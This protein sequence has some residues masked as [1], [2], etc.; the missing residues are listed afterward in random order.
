MRYP[1]SMFTGGGGRISFSLC[2]M[3]MF[4]KTAAFS[5]VLVTACAGTGGHKP[6]DYAD[7]IVYEPEKVDVL[8]THREWAGL[9][10]HHGYPGYEQRHYRVGLRGPGPKFVNPKF[11][12]NPP[13]IECV[14]SVNL[15]REHNRVTLDMRR[16]VSQ[17]GESMRTKAHPANGTYVILSTRKAGSDE[18]CL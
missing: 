11:Q 4:A 18:P 17:P 9:F 13:T 15:N 12:D 2:S 5:L 14:G 10:G 16:V 6:N 7:L 8:I 1:R 3:R